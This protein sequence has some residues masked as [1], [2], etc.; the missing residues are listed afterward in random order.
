MTLTDV[1][2]ETTGVRTTDPHTTLAIPNRDP[3]R[4]LHTT[5]EEVPAKN[6]AFI[7]FATSYL[8]PDEA[9][10]LQERITTFTE[11]AHPALRDYVATFWAATNGTTPFMQEEVHCIATYLAHE[12]AINGDPVTTIPRR[13]KQQRQRGTVTEL[14]QTTNH[15]TQEILDHL[16]DGVMTPPTWINTTSYRNQYM[17]RETWDDLNDVFDTLGSDVT[18]YRVTHA[19]L[20]FDTTINTVRRGNIT[21]FYAY[22]RDNR[23]GNFIP[24]ENIGP[25]T[26]DTLES[27]LDHHEILRQ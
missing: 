12:G 4:W 27:Y 1:V 22:L 15:T 3:P 6:D 20:Q 10:T 5:Y 7:N 16:R 21:D 11:T 2:E 24:F 9:T 23:T 19:V 8:S 26:Y 18:P 25:V 14:R 17:T 13:D